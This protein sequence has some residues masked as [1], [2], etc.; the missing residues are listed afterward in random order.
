MCDSIRSKVKMMIKVKTLKTSVSWTFSSL[1]LTLTISVPILKVGWLSFKLSKLDHTWGTT[2][3]NTH[4]NHWELVLNLD[5]SLSETRMWC[6]H[7]LKQQKWCLITTLTGCARVKNGA[8][9]R[10]AEIARIIELAKKSVFTGRLL[11]LWRNWEQLVN[12]F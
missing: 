3:S 7:G 8:S 12:Q 1:I 11:L 9:Q 5:R 6:S 2:R 4:V 10:A